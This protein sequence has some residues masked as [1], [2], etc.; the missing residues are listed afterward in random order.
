MRQGE[1]APGGK[2]DYII[3]GHMVAGFALVAYPVDWSSSGVMTFIMGPN[4]DVFEKDLGAKTTELAAALD[5]FDPDETWK[6]S[7][8]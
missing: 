2:Y 1:H 4:G 7:K 5:T 6:L 8:D 3:N